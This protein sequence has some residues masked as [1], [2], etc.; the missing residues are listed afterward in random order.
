MIT[1]GR[2]TKM[3]GASPAVA[4]VSFEVAPG[5][6]L[7]IVGAPGSGKSSLLRVLA[8]LAAPSSGVVRIAGFDVVAEIDRIRPHVAFTDGTILPGEGLRV[9]DY[10]DVPARAR[11][12]T[13]AEARAAVALALSRAELM[14][15]E[16][17]DALTTDGRARLA[18]AAALCAPADLLVLDDPLR[19]IESA[20]RGQLAQWIDERHAAGATIVV[21]AEML[22]GLPACCQRTLRLARGTA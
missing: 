7:G 8:T 18:L 10:L 11:Q 5:E 19:P 12:R 15:N 9:A 2:L 17:V 14:A 21:A 16:D 3:F 22:S 1:V 4:G 6:C 20:A 13:K